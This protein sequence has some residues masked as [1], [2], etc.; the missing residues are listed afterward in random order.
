MTRKEAFIAQRT[1]ELRAAGKPVD[2][3]QLEARFNELNA[4]DAGKAQIAEKVS[5]FNGPAKTPLLPPAAA[6]AAAPTPTTTPTTPSM[7]YDPTQQAVVP[8]SEARVST[9]QAP[10]PTTPAATP[11]ATNSIPGFTFGAAAAA[12]A[13]PKPLTP[14]Q[15]AATYGT[16]K[17][18]LAAMHPGA[19]EKYISDGTGLSADEAKALQAQFPNLYKEFANKPGGLGG[20]LPFRPA[21]AVPFTTGGTTPSSSTT[22]SGSTTSG[23]A[24]AAP[25]TT[26]DSGATNSGQ[27]GESLWEK[28]QRLLN[29]SN[30]K[31]T[32]EFNNA[33]A[34]IK[35]QM[36]EQAAKAYNEQKLLT[37]EQIRLINE[38][39]A[40]LERDFQNRRAMTMGDIANLQSAGRGQLSQVLRE[41]AAGRRSGLLGLASRN[42][43]IDP[44]A[45]RRF[46]N[47]ANTSQAAALGATQAGTFGQVSRLRQQLEQDERDKATRLADLSRLSTYLGTSIPNYFPGVS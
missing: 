1:K 7:T 39:R 35:A 41:F 30:E 26:P 10:A 42:R 40:G 38:G 43:G 12:A 18:A 15:A 28:Y 37:A 27:S 31:N 3:A 6:P 2:V 34:K 4:T 8:T 11:A 16:F 14:Q 9:G 29:E 47:E 24:S 20:A 32:A 25:G 21:T 46:I 23:T 17:E 36:D 19:V 13:A 22:P 44:S 45:S 5:L 33:L